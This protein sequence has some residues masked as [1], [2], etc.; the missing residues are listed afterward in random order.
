MAGQGN[1]AELVPLLQV[2]SW[3]KGLGGLSFALMAV[4]VDQWWF[5]FP[6]PLGALS[7]NTS[8]L[9]YL[10]GS[11]F[12]GDQG[13]FRSIW[14]RGEN[15]GKV[16]LA[17]GNSTGRRLRVW[18]ERKAYVNMKKNTLTVEREES[19]QGKAWTCVRAFWISGCVFAFERR[20]ILGTEPCDRKGL[21]ELPPPPFWEL[22]FTSHSY[23]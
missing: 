6:V 15:R 22:D 5:I 23:C 12:R 16:I 7:P 13:Y 14:K 17:G 8:R 9:E 19:R 20:E 3:L 21:W 18:R 11:S 4:R 10:P 1:P 2:L